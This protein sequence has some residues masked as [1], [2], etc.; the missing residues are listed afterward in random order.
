MAMDVDEDGSYNDGFVD[1]AYIPMT[2][3]MDHQSPASIL[4]K[5]EMDESENEESSQMFE[6]AGV[7]YQA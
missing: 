2:D 7:S 3:I 6:N 5:S 1:E 4:E